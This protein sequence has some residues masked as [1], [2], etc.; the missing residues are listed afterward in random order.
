LDVLRLVAE[1]RKDREV[2]ETL[3]IS[4]RTVT[5]HVTNILNKL[6]AESRSAAVAYAVRHGLV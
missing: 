3:F 5:T 4:R 2:A 6:G 1:G